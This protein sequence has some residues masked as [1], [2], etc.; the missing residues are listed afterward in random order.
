MKV[1]NAGLHTS[2]CKRRAHMDTIFISSRDNLC[3]NSSMRNMDFNDNTLSAA[4]AM[5]AAGAMD[6][7]DIICAAG[8]MGAMEAAGVAVPDIL[9]PDASRCD[10]GKW[11]VVACDQ[12]T[13]QPSYWA[14][15]EK[16]VGDS[17]SAL[18]LALPE[19]YL[20]DDFANHISRVHRTMDDY[21]DRC[22]FLQPF[23]GFILTK[24]T[25]AA[26][27]PDTRGAESRWGL[28]AA[29][30]LD[31]YSFEPD[32]KTL[33]RST[34]E[35]APDRLPP[36]LEIRRGASLE[37][38]HV[39]VLANDRKCALIEPLVKKAEAGLYKKAYDFELM[40]DGGRICGYYIENPRIDMTAAFKTLYA[41]ACD[42]SDC[43]MLFAVGDGNHSMA[44][45]KVY[46]DEVKCSLSPDA[47]ASHPAR[48]ALAEIVNF[49]S[50]AVRFEPIHRALYNANIK[51]L[52][53]EAHSFSIKM[54]P[55]RGGEARDNIIY[56]IIYDRVKRAAIKSEL[57]DS[58][59][60]IF[61]LQNFLDFYCK[62]HPYVSLDY[63]HGSDELDRLAREEGCI[64]FKLPPLKKS[65][66]FQMISEKGPLPRKSFSMGEANDKRYYLEARKII[67]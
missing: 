26:K 60:P 10:Y 54:D 11:A 20:N 3:Y 57:C 19:I 39:L 52:A 4:D 41:D 36:R 49:Y 24:R 53:N 8:V 21:I 14:G 28:I 2:D 35:T 45:A 9:L 6:A 30:D 51:D 12:Y 17:P 23:S 5:D 29:I 1:A 13:S 42:S 25:F 15:I 33:I 18:R 47:R 43:P 58:S 38:P 62:K 67:Y 61:E 56:E 46:W 34:E 16:T 31:A 40:A 55:I 48:Y 66:F 64:C 50:E 44:A 22:I 27:Q 65:G 32:A 37:L 63:I 59:L 7:A